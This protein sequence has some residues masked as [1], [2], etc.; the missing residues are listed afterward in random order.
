MSTAGADTVRLRVGAPA[1][2]DRHKSLWLW[3]PLPALSAVLL[4]VLVASALE[5]PAREQASEPFSKIK[6]DL[7]EGEGLGSG[8]ADVPPW[9]ADFAAA[10]AGEA[11]ASAPR[12][13]PA[14]QADRRVRSADPTPPVPA[15]AGDLTPN[16][17]RALDRNSDGRMSPAEFA[18]YRLDG[19]RPNHKG[20]KADDMA[21]Y[22]STQAL[23]QTIV[24]FR[25][26]DRNNDWF[27]S[28][29]EFGSTG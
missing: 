12:L 23:N 18:I 26:L 14:A 7:I 19:V 24:E 13:A 10:P 27:V 28:P 17:F 8:T 20:N 16:S 29:V 6:V 4:W 22:V 9:P 25:R 5:D 15:R 21:P 2:K 3:I 11:G 1:E